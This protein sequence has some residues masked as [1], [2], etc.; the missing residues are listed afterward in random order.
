MKL[1]STFTL[2]H[3]H[4][5]PPHLRHLISTPILIGVVVNPVLDLPLQKDVAGVDPR[6][7]ERKQKRVVHA[8]EM[9]LSLCIEIP[10]PIPILPVRRGSLLG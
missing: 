3:T 5:K 1:N 6:Q 4:P 2:T 10:I 7:L 9:N 8:P